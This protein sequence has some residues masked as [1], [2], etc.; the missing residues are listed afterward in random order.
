MVDDDDVTV[1]SDDFL[2][3][4]DNDSRDSQ[5]ILK[6]FDE[7]IIGHQ[8]FLND[9]DEVE[10][11]HRIY[12]NSQT[13]FKETAHSNTENVT[14]TNTVDIK[15]TEKDKNL[16]KNLT[17]Q[18]LNEPKELNTDVISTNFDLNAR[19]E[20]G[21]K[22]HKD[23][24]VGNVNDISKNVNV[25]TAATFY[26]SQKTQIYSVHGYSQNYTHYSQSQNNVT[27]PKQYLYQNRNNTNRMD[28]TDVET[29]ENSEIVKEND[30]IHENFN[31]DCEVWNCNNA[32]TEERITK[33]VPNNNI[34]DNA[35]ITQENN[36]IFITN[37]NNKYSET[38]KELVDHQSQ[39]SQNIDEYF[40][41]MQNVHSD[42]IT[43]IINMDVDDNE[44]NNPKNTISNSIS[45]NTARNDG[46]A[47]FYK[48]NLHHFRDFKEGLLTNE[49]V[50]V[51]PVKHDENFEK[52]YTNPSQNKDLS[53]STA[54]NVHQNTDFTDNINTNSTEEFPSN[55][56][57]LLRNKDLTEEYRITEEDYDSEEIISFKVLE[58]FN[59]VKLF[60]RRPNRR[61]SCD[62]YSSDSGYKSDSQRSN[63]SAL[64]LSGTWLNQSGSCLFHYLLQC[65]LVAS[66]R[67]ITSEIAQ[68]L[69]EL[70]DKLHDDEKYPSFLEELL[71]TIDGELG[72]V[73]EGANSE[74]NEARAERYAP[75]ARV[76]FW[77]GGELP[78]L[79]VRRPAL[80]MAGDRPL[81]PDAPSV[82]CC[83]GWGVRRR[84]APPRG[85]PPSL[86]A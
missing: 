4:D 6:D 82:A 63:R 19:M 18:D 9:V 48:V 21:E 54:K 78:L 5:T 64:Q 69:G 37:D 41:E 49:S 34:E 15:I 11:L 22:Y 33:I 23:S 50:D 73:F 62:S 79:A 68:V 77:S 32:I 30:G 38:N 66:T 80:T 58:E 86:R 67:D 13:T 45:E 36:D 39:Y 1:C 85:P 46:K 74:E 60:V 12:N 59:K 70:I 57:N 71:E 81:I 3:D 84:I 76:W 35:F 10:P 24:K 61:M 7:E 43:E 42:K 75:Y 52:Y 25:D 26:D 14:K 44:E 2:M 56:T 51:I 53:E 31:N 65:P 40:N 83:G 17:T 16:S 27:I 8:I 20:L 72:Q 28:A 29:Q 47:K 55:R